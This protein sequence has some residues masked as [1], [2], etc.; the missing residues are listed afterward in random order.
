ML[1]MIDPQLDMSVDEI[2]SQALGSLYTDMSGEAPLALCAFRD[3]DALLL[4]LRFDRELLEGADETRF[5]PLSALSFMALPE[6]VAEVVRL[7]ASRTPVPGSL[8]VSEER[9][10][11]VFAFSVLDVACDP[12]VV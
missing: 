4:L 12:D 10:L 9:G 3:G 7:R 1:Q 11:A 6:L 8:S 5:G 2:A